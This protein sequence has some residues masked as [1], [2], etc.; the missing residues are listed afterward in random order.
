[1]IRVRHLSKFFLSTRGKIEAVRNVSLDVEKGDVFGIIGQSG[2]G[3]STLI[4][5]L[6]SLEK[7][8][9]GEIFIE[10]CDIAQMSP[11]E[12]HHFRKKIGMVFQHFNLLASRNVAGN[13]AY[14]LEIHGIPKLERKKRLDEVLSLVDLEQKREAY[15]A[16][17]SGGQKQRVGIARALASNP[18]V[19]FCDEATSALDPNTTR[20]ILA[21][22]KKLNQTLGLTIVLIT[23]EMDVIKQ[24]CNKVAV[25]DKGEIV[26]SGSIAKVFSDPQHPTTKLLLQNSIHEVPRSFFK[27][28]SPNRKLLRL[29]FKGQKA[30]EPI[31]SNM[32]RRFDVEVNILLGWIDSLQGMIIGNLVIELEA[33]EAKLEEALRFLHQN[34]VNFEELQN[35]GR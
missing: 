15:P 17:L 14:P 21:L 24:I 29:T 6:S 22:L 20:A 8:S 9:E 7:P 18:S 32:I 16:Q 34:E 31:I 19:L 3:K 4:R 26:E 33:P 35:V 12:L 10:E 11:R 23:H 2:A 25:L 27:E 28:L 5:C 1:V 13:V 30:G